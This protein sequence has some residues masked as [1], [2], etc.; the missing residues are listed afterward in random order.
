[1]IDILFMGIVVFACLLA[2][3]AIGGCAVMWFLV[4]STNRAGAAGEALEDEG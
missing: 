1:M 4:L 2:G 3:G